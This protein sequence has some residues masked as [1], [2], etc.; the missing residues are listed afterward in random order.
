[1]D[2]EMMEYWNDDFKKMIFFYL[3]PVKRSFTIPLFPSILP[4]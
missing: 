1:M 3:T 4:P 2:I